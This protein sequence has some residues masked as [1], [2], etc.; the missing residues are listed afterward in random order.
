MNILS[1][2]IYTRSDGAVVDTFK[3]CE[4]GSNHPLRKEQWIRVEQ[5]LLKAFTGEYDV[6]AA[7]EKWASRQRFRTRRGRRR[8]KLTSV[9]FDQSSSASATVIEVRSDD[10]PGLAYRVSDRLAAMGL[11]IQ[12]AKLATE[13]GHILDVFYLT[14]SS[15][16]KLPDELLPEVERDVLAATAEPG[17]MREAV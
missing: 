15:G 5:N 6:T 12:F 13:K 17:E 1:A 2:D 16:E 4:V 10:E 11:N 9:T 14:G 8:R 7:V 3:V